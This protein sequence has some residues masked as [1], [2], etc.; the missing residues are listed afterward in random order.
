LWQEISGKLSRYGGLYIYRDGIRVLPYGNS[1]FDFLDIEVRRAKSA[2][3]AF[4]S[5]R[6]MFGVIELS[7][8][9][10]SSL[11]EK[12]GRE[13]FA[14][15][16][17][18]RQFREILK[19][20][21]Y[22]VAVDFFRLSGTRAERYW[23]E[24]D[25]LNRLDQ[26][27]GR[28][29]RQTR[30]RRKSFS[31]GLD[32]FFE[33]MGDDAPTREVNEVLSNLEGRLVSA[34]ARTDTHAASTG[35][36]SAE[37]GARS[38]LRTLEDGYVVSRPRG[39]GLTKTQTKLWMAYENERARLHQQVFLP[40]YEFVDRKVTASFTAAGMAVDR[41][42]RFDEAVRAASDRARESVRNARR[43]LDEAIKQASTSTHELIRDRITEADSQIQDV[44]ARAS[45]FDVAEL[46]DERFTSARA[47]FEGELSDMTLAHV[48]ALASVTS[49]IARIVWPETSGIE[50]ITFDDQVEALETD[51]DA[52]REQT[53][54]DLELAQLGAAIEVINHEFEG[55]INAIRR[56]L[57]RIKSWADMNP[58]LRDPYHDL[59]ASFE[60]LDGYLRLFTPF[61]R[62]LY[63]TKI[64]ISGAEIEK[65]LRDVFD[66]KLEASDTVL[67]ATKKFADA[68]I[69]Q[70][71]SV[72]YPVFVNL[73]D[74][75]LY[76]LTDYRGER[77]I[78]LDATAE[79]LIVRDSGP[80][81]SPRDRD[82][83]FDFGFSRKP[84]G[85][86][87][88]L[89][90]SQEVLR[91][92]GWSLTLSAATANAGAEFVLRDDQRKQENGS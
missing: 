44:L 89:Y 20:F 77:R 49:Q 43:E 17:A 51:L 13:G 40:A 8:D 7:R 46:S 39:V 91:R 67:T 21:L 6:R 64:E 57:R 56:S 71:P 54:R 48:S 9:R 11:R 81:V 72:L 47:S 90:I 32:T 50:Q 59:R 53:E 76:W 52:L 27:R 28:R 83:I 42:L 74:N 23:S 38:E 70:Y 34:V 66:R 87:Y 61:H 26:A 1:D 62:R 2:S 73:V 45:R 82:A 33:R 10:N 5:Y 88:G 30:M 60:H 31:D 75:A 58:A 55:T 16:E 79:I 4:F 92:E 22:Q 80:G 41:R 36:A 29:A 65:Y 63:R 69:M 78:T 18:Y 35:I 24:R 68:R 12:A 85:T 15:N 84:G 25:E 86:G 19:H 3:D 14:D 37:A